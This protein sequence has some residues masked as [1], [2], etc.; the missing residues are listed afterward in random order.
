MDGQGQEQEQIKV[1]TDDQNTNSAEIVDYQTSV[2]SS[3]ETVIILNSIE[4]F[5]IFAVIGCLVGKQMWDKIKI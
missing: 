4:C 5:L 1:T 2:I 3:L